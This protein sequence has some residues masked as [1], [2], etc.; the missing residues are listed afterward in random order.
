MNTQCS[1][2]C[3]LCY[4]LRAHARDINESR[5]SAAG[6]ADALSLSATQGIPPSLH[7]M[8]FLLTACLSWSSTTIAGGGVGS[9]GRLGGGGAG[10]G[11]ASGAL[12]L[13]PIGGAPSHPLLPTSDP[14]DRPI[15]ECLLFVVVMHVIS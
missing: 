10:G 1:C 11:A 12:S 4:E 6:N 2:Q 8:L 13:R 3:G 5:K 14:V 7:C 9:G 15:G